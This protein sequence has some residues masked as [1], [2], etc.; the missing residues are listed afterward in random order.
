M[1][2]KNGF[3]LS[4]FIM[5]C[6]CA[7]T[8]YEKTF[9]NPV[10]YKANEELGIGSP[11][12]VFY[13]KTQTVTQV[14]SIVLGSFIVFKDDSTKPFAGV[15]LQ[16]QFPNYLMQLDTIIPGLFITDTNQSTPLFTYTYNNNATIDIY[17][18]FLDTVKLDIE[19]TGH[20]ADILFTPLIVG[21]DSIYYNLQSCEIIDHEDNAIEVNGI[22]G[23]EVIID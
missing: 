17:T 10:D 12:L 23:A 7:C 2:S 16:I 11:S 9:D 22:R 3:I 1:K 6:I 21:S 4:L 5:I 8:I 20:I 19:G 15:H 13:P 18:Y 14:D